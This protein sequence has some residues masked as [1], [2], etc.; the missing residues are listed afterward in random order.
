MKSSRSVGEVRVKPLISRALRIHHRQRRCGDDGREDDIDLEWDTPKR[1]KEVQAFLGFANFH[2]RFFAGYSRVHK[3]LT[4]VTKTKDLT[5]AATT[6]DLIAGTDATTMKATK[7]T[8]FNLTRECDDV[9]K[10]LKNTLHN[11]GYSTSFQPDI[12]RVR[13]RSRTRKSTRKSLTHKTSEHCTTSRLLDQRQARWAQELSGYD[14]KMI[15][16]P[17]ALNGKPDNQS[18]RSEY[19][20]EKGQ[21]EA[22]DG[23]QLRVIRKEQ[24][25]FNDQPSAERQGADPDDGPERLITRKDGDENRRR[26]QTD[27]R[28]DDQAIQSY[29]PLPANLIEGRRKGVARGDAIDEAGGI[30]IS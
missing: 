16:Q 23:S 2:R 13:D 18:R 8:R 29:L 30:V 24:L 11:R 15:Y 1:I 7:S 10:E 17:R 12:K 26:A 20:H 25:I 19:R 14:F 5:G 28:G 27:M 22:G 6:K 3:P 9:F 4:D 21:V